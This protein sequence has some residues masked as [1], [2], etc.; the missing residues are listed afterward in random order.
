[1]PENFNHD[2]IGQIQGPK[3]VETDFERAGLFIL[4][5]TTY[6][7]G[8]RS[9]YPTSLVRGAQT[10]STYPHLNSAIASLTKRRQDIGDET[11]EYR[12]THV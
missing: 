12:L 11:E 7:L 6:S 2:S 3:A 4:G 5:R 1:M 8:K 10:N 9:W